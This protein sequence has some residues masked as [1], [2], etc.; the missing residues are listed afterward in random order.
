MTTNNVGTL[1]TAL[2]GFGLW[3]VLYL[4]IYKWSGEAHS[5]SVALILILPA[6]I[7]AFVLRGIMNSSKA[8]TQTQSDAAE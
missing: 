6:L 3:S 2:I 4:Q 7:L 1:A 5:F 8:Q